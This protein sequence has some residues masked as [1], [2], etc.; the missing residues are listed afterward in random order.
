MGADL[1][2]WR[3]CPLQATL[4]PWEFYRRMKTKVVR[5]SAIEELAEQKLAPTTMLRLH[6]PELWSEPRAVTV[7][8]LTEEIGDFDKGVPECAA[9]P[10]ARGHV[11]GCYS[12]IHYPIDVEAEEALFE[13]FVATV[14]DP[15][16][17]SAQLYNELMVTID[18]SSHPWHSQ[19]GGPN[20]FCAR[21]QPLQHKWG[22]F[23]SKRK[24]DSAQLLAA[25]LN[26]A[27]GAPA[28]TA[29][30]LFWKEFGEFL[31]RRGPGPRSTST[32]EFAEL[33]SLYLPLALSGQGDVAVLVHAF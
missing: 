11:L 17:A 5:D 3:G 20:A 30:A 32:N 16:S 23:F 27:R 29:Y 18:P 33:A 19:R 28:V 8:G 15:E 22:G 10:I 21:P 26:T 7:Q 6:V 2:G 31:A 1:I 14:Q 25:L 4:D 9:C 12:N 13:F 24:T